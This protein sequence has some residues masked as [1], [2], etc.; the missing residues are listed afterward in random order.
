MEAEWKQEGVW[1][2]GQ[3]IEH[4]ETRFDAINTIDQMSAALYKLRRE[5]IG[6]SPNPY[7]PGN[8]PVS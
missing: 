5:L 1:L 7:G 2:N 8:G 6:E 4:A 3:Y